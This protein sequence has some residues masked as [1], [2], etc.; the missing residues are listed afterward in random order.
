MT[1]KAFGK[2][3]DLSG[4]QISMFC[5]FDG[6][7]SIGDVTDI[8]LEQLANPNWHIIEERWQAGELDDY[9]CMAQQISLIN[10]NWQDIVSVLEKIKLDENFK[11]IYSFMQ[12]GK[13]SCFY[14]QQWH[15]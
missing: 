11:S 6:T 3:P 13:N 8:L 2:M 12:T 7:I 4:K 10:G 5:D 14:W 9:E 15:R 1:E